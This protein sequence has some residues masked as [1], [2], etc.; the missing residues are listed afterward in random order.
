MAL[1]VKKTGASPFMTDEQINR[2]PNVCRVIV[3]DDREIEALC[4]DPVV[5][6]EEFKKL[7]TIR[8]DHTRDA[9]RLYMPLTVKDGP[10]ATV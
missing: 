10:Q 2:L 4:C 9:A 8:R 7:R 5:S 6:F 3:N 1:T